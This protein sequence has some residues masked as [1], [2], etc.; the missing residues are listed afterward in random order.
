MPVSSPSLD[1]SSFTFLIS[2]NFNCLAP[3]LFQLIVE[4]VSLLTQANLALWKASL[5]YCLNTTLFALGS[6]ISLN[7]FLR[8]VPTKKP[9]GIQERQVGVSSAFNSQKVSPFKA[10][11]TWISPL[12]APVH[13]TSEAI[14]LKLTKGTF[15]DALD[16]FEL[17]W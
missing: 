16:S 5:I 6:K 10:F 12:K 15:F 7:L 14:G 17:P 1:K 13:T 4:K 2:H 8:V 11:Q 9:F 3:T